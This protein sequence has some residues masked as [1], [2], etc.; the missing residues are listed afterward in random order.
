MT[1]AKRRVRHLYVAIWFYIGNSC[2]FLAIAML[3]V[4]N[5]LEVPLTFGG[6]KSY[7]AYAGVKD[8]LVQ[9]WYGHSACGFRTDNARFL[10]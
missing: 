4:F 7:S 5:N 10:V 9:W 8:A 1:I 2:G 6:W 3:H